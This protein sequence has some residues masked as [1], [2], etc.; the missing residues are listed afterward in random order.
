[1]ICL[2]LPRGPIGFILCL[3]LI[4]TASCAENRSEEARA[5][6][7]ENHL[8]APCCWRPL[9]GHESQVADEMRQEIRTMVAAGMDRQAILDRF[10]ARYGEQVLA[11]PH[12]EGFNRLLN[13]LPWA[14]LVLGGWI[15]YVLLKNQRKP[16][17]APPPPEPPPDSR[18]ASEIEKELKDLEEQ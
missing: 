16:S 12:A 1:M 5:R 7:I 10:V 4:F 6:E 18:Y 9:P 13:I 8:M 17:V 3:F 14:A 11:E 15:V 2:K